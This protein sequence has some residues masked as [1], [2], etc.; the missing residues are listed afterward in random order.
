MTESL[1]IGHHGALHA[2]ICG[3]SG[4][5][6]VAL[7]T[8]LLNRSDVARV[9]ASSRQATRSPQLLDQLAKHPGR[10]QIIDADLTDRDSLQRLAVAL[11]TSALQLT[12]NAAGLLHDGALM[13]EKNLAAVNLA[14]LQQVFAVNAFGPILLAQ[15]VL[16]RMRGTPAVFASLSARVGSIG[17]NR[18]GG[19]YAYRAAK[20]A[21]NQ[22]LKT[23]SIETQRSHPA[24][25][26]QLLHPGTVDSAL[27]RPF[28]RGVAPQKLFDAAFAAERLLAVIATATP[29]NS[30]RFVAWDGSTVPW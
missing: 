6:G 23:L 14:G 29:A 5:L 18:L 20:A 19:W 21:Q 26:V 8:A 24:L 25:S 11:G 2:L 13:P 12:I 9:S 3:A 27:S 1:I 30:G 22:L 28:Q 17:D 16:P 4:G 7:V 15:A 10:L